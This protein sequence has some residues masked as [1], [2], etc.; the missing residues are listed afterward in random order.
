LYS[1]GVIHKEDYERILAYKRI[2]EEKWKKY[3][4]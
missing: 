4:L 1:K 3:I 2:G